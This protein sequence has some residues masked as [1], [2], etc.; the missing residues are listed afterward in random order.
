[1]KAVTITE[2]ERIED[3]EKESAEYKYLLKKH[4]KRAIDHHGEWTDKDKEN[5]G[6][7]YSVN[8]LN[9]E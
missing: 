3:E 7:W 6:R 1:M 4:K 2:K 5:F 9:H 8:K